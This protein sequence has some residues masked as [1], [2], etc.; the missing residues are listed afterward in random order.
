MLGDPPVVSAFAGVHSCGRFALD[1]RS[2]R[3]AAPGARLSGGGLLVIL[4]SAICWLRVWTARVDKRTRKRSALS[5]FPASGLGVDSNIGVAMV[6]RNFLVK[7][8]GVHH[9]TSFGDQH[10]APDPDRSLELHLQVVID[11]R[12]GFTYRKVMDGNAN[13]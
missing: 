9:R 3:A 4:L 12:E 5:R 10:A 1:L 2:A 11:R 13:N 7:E 8:R 6:R